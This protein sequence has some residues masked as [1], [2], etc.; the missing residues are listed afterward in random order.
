MILLRETARNHNDFRNHMLFSMALG[1][2]LRVNELCALEIRDVRNGK[3]AKG[4]IELR[5]ETTKNK[6]G[7]QIVLP[8]RLRRK[9]ARFLKWKIERG[10]PSEP[11]SPLFIARGGGRA[12]SKGI[13]RLS[14]RSAQAAFTT[15]QERLGFDRH[16]NFHMLRHS[17]ATNLWKKTGDLRLVQMACR[18]S[19]PVVTS[20]Y[21]VPTT[22]DV[23]I[24]VQDLPC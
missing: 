1:T 2:G 9:M 5:K 19:T 10:E 17:F 15:W 20:I 21:A 6:K 14:K 24:A 8:E 11:R 18:H 12:G 23:L 7:G 16:C 13:K 22:Q 4:V 3:G